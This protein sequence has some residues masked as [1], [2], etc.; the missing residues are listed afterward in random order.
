MDNYEAAAAAS[1]QR[2]KEKH[3]AELEQMIEDA[4]SKHT[5]KYT[6]SRELMH[7]RA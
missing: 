1:V 7:V 2:L 6:L 3:V 5:V 4:Y